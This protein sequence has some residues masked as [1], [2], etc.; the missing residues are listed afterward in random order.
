MQRNVYESKRGLLGVPP[1]GEDHPKRIMRLNEKPLK[2][3]IKRIKEYLDPWKMEKKD[4]IQPW[5]VVTLKLLVTSCAH[6]S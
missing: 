5:S 4:Q 3:V 6:F 2:I 1:G